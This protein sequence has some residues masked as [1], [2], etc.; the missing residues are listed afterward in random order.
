M[1]EYQVTGFDF[2]DCWSPPALALPVPSIL[3]LVI[4]GRALKKGIS[5]QCRE[6]ELLSEC[7]H[8]SLHAV[9]ASVHDKAVRP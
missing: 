3:L 6:L 8:K 9:E 5:G 7:K 1:Q 2:Q 4:Q